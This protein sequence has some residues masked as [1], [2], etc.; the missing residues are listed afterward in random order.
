[1]PPES[2]SYIQVP[3]N[4]VLSS[5]PATYYKANIEKVIEKVIEFTIA[6]KLFKT[7]KDGRTALSIYRK[8]RRIFSPIEKRALASK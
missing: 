2:S 4:P 5:Q 6:S 3:G 7:E 1:M 8:A